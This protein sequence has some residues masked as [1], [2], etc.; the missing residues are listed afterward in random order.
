MIDTHCHILPDLDDGPESMTESLDL[1]RALVADGIDAVIATPHQLGMFDNADAAG[2]ICQSVRDLNS[3]LQQKDIPLTVYP[4][5]EVRLDVSIGRLLKENK[6]LTLANGGRYLLLELPEEVLIDITPL[7]RD[8]AARGIVIVIAHAERLLKAAKEPAILHR[9]LAAGAV[10]QI[11]AS[12]LSGEWGS[13]IAHFG[14]QLI[15]DGQASLLATD[16]HHTVTRRPRLS[17]AFS[18]VSARL[19]E[20]IARR[21]MID[22]PAAI[23]KGACLSPLFQYQNQVKQVAP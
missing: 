5:A 9:W 18:A 11:S 15:L 22:N 3:V 8:F 23:L 6:I 21:L 10:L 19:G 4:G 17:E 16:A 12:G 14:W 20:K 2:R 1:A 7:V 13:G